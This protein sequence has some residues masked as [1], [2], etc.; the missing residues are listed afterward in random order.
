MMRFTEFVRRERLYILLLVFVIL[1][2]AIFTMS[3]RTKAK[4]KSAKAGLEEKK[5]GED[6]SVKRHQMEKLLRENK[7]L[8]IIFTLASLLIMLVLFL[9]LAI[10]VIFF[11]R[12]SHLPVR[13]PEMGGL[14][15]SESAH[16]VFILR[17]HADHD[18]IVPCADVPDNKE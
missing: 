15:R 14:G 16:T 8:A 5:P 6:Q 1:I 17:L 2:S 18:R 7:S 10:D 9:G 3:S 12:H 11:A 4:P 13:F